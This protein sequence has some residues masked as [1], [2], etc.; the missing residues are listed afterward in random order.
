MQAGFAPA[1]CIESD[2]ARL[3]GKKLAKFDRYVLSRR[4]QWSNNPAVSSR[5]LIHAK[6]KQSS[7]LTN[8]HFIIHN[9]ATK[10]NL[11]F[12]VG[13]RLALED[14]S[15]FFDQLALAQRTQ[16][17]FLTTPNLSRGPAAYFD[18]RFPIADSLVALYEG[19]RYAALVLKAGTAWR[20]VLASDAP[21]TVLITSM[22]T[23]GATPAR[24]AASGSRP[25]TAMS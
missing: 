17:S 13:T 20:S 8:R 12:S 16:R 7:K 21:M 10:S 14:I 25:A 24:N 15:S 1:G 18:R 3:T 11:T 6:I 19:E 23:N 22:T 2:Q 5:A 4:R 9:N